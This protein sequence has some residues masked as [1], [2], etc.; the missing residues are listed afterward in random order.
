MRKTWRLDTIYYQSFP[1]K[2]AV[3]L[4]LMSLE[5]MI[6]YS[7]DIRGLTE[8][9]AQ[10][11]Q[12]HFATAQAIITAQKQ[13]ANY[14]KMQTQ[15]KVW[16]LRFSKALQPLQQPFELSDL[17]QQLSTQTERNGLKLQ[18][19]TPLQSRKIG[20]FIIHSIQLNTLT[21]YPAFSQFIEHLGE[22]PF[23]LK[24]ANFALATNKD[25][26]Q[27]TTTITIEIYK[28]ASLA[29][30]STPNFAMLLKKINSLTFPI[31]P[32]PL[33]MPVLSDPFTQRTTAKK[34][35]ICQQQNP[36]TCFPLNDYQVLGVIQQKD[37]YWGI[38]LDPQG[39]L[40]QV[41]TGMQLGNQPN[42][43]SRIDS[44]AI[45]MSGPEQLKIAVEKK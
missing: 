38:L 23:G 42:R 25:P 1:K 35:A 3:I 18:A 30:I 15:L 20:V 33:G 31:E 7:L 43:I 13:I 41:T 37:H 34:A 39:N 24:V 12:A 16:Q 19:I 6:G 4:L 11:K 36:L 40:H 44:Q 22:L 26:T 27:L 2:L 21:D 32:S 9:L 45:T 8:Q 5:L 29:K 14:Q 10:I 28:F 17:L